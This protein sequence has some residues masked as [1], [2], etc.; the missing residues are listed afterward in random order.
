MKYTLL[1][2][3]VLVVS[4]NYLLSQNTTKFNQTIVSPH[5]RVAVS[6]SENIVW[7][8]TFQQIGRASCW[9]RESSPE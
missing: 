7:C 9:E 1:T 4:I 6:G 2:I 3:I 5:L 8:F